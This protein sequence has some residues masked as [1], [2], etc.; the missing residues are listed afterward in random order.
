[1]TTKHKVYYMRKLFTI[2]LIFS[3]YSQIFGQ[4]LHFTNNRFAPIQFNPSQ[5]G[6]FEGSLRAGSI[7]RSQFSDFIQ[8]P[9][10]SILLYV[11]A[12]LSFSLRKNDWTG[13]G[14][15]FYKDRA[16]D[17]SLTNTGMM[18]GVSYHLSSDAKYTRVLSLGA[19]YGLNFRTLDVNSAIFPDFLQSGNKG[20]DF[21]KLNNLKTMS[22]D[23]NV[24]LSYKQKINKTNIFQAG[25]GLLYAFRSSFDA[26]K[27]PY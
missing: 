17:L 7:Y 6:A 26:I 11:D 2:I 18:G 8:R 3:I 4:D 19:T 9:Y 12:P 22:G 1:M 16:G 27:Y 14:V 21:N 15:Q 25:I 24:G 23:L 13:I 10:E 20:N 5:I